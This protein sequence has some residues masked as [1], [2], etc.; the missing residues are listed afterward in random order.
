[1]K[2]KWTNKCSKTQST[3]DLTS[4]HSLNSGHNVLIPLL[5]TRLWFRLCYVLSRCTLYMPY[6]SWSSWRSTV[7]PAHSDSDTV[8]NV[9]DSVYR[10]FCFTVISNTVRA[11]QCQRIHQSSSVVIDSER[12]VAV[13]YYLIIWH[14]WP[15]LVQCQFIL[16]LGWRIPRRVWRSL[17]CGALTSICWWHNLHWCRYEA[18]ISLHV[19]E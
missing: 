15:D 3:V 12:Y 11:C 14:P 6:G 1:M 8:G 2:F 16:L 9:N 4:Y 10:R 13:N 7:A 5:F 19:S 18:R 17:F